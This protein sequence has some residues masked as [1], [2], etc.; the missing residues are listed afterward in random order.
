MRLTL[1]K[2]K[3]LIREEVSR[4]TLDEGDSLARAQARYD[5]M[6]PP[7]YDELE[8]P[9][10]WDVMSKDCGDDNEAWGRLTR[11][12]DEWEIPNPHAPDAPD[13]VFVTYTPAARIVVAASTVGEAG[14]DDENYAYVSGKVWGDKATAQQWQELDDK[15]YK[16]YVDYIKET[17]ADYQ[18]ERDYEARQ[19]RRGW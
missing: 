4:L 8:P 15:S 16:D 1:G 19:E 10:D 2:L 14:E 18:A 6:L 11:H 13:T 17:E 12:C 3:E 9:E 5:N 7:E